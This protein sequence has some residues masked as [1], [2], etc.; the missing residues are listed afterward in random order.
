[1]HETLE[2]QAKDLKSKV[3]NV[4]ISDKITQHDLQNKIEKNI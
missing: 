1:M 2:D 3:L 4:Q